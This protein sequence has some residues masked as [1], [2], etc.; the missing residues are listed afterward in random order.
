M[1]ACLRA[2]VFAEQGSR[3]GLLSAVLLALTGADCVCQWSWGDSQAVQARV[4]AGH[5]YST[6]PQ[7]QNHEIG[8][9]S[10]DR[11]NREQMLV[12]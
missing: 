12:V 3:F 2:A 4:W 10:V 1:R 11:S 9:L 6:G 5:G 8:L 7:V